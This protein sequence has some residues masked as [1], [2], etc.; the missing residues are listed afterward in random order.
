MVWCRERVAV[1]CPGQA[2]GQALVCSQPHFNE[3][4]T[5][6]DAEQRFPDSFLS[7]PS[8]A[9]TTPTAPEYLCLCLCSALERGKGDRG[10]VTGW[11]GVAGEAGPESVAVATL[12]LRPGDQSGQHRHQIGRSL[13]REGAPGPCSSG[14][15]ARLCLWEACSQAPWCVHLSIAASH[16]FPKC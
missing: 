7:P 8:W 5:R 14:M 16:L 13:P 3:I 10:P 6:I 15:P 11:R 1:W 9:V 4:V 12:R 2:P